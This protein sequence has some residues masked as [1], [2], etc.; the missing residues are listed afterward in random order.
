MDVTDLP[1]P[2]SP[3]SPRTSPWL[4]CRSTPS[5]ALTTPCLREEVRL[6]D[7]FDLE[8]RPSRRR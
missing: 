8:Q 2:D 3:T 6:A 4:T 1:Q 5:T 7:P